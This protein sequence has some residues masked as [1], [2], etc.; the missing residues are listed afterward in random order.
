MIHM[1]ESAR[2]LI[3]DEDILS[4]VSLSQTLVRGG[5]TISHATDHERAIKAVK[6]E[7]PDLI[8]CN[9]GGQRLNAKELVRVVGQKAA[10]KSI[11]FLFI[12]ESHPETV[13]APEI[14]GPR[15]YLTKPFTREQVLTAVQQHLKR[16]KSKTSR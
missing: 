7:K 13:S 14:L 6:D 16:R 15:Q 8:I 1:A 3:V 12:V 9:L 10:H 2:I 11:P 5:F 4:I